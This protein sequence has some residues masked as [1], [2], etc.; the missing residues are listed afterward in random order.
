MY[1]TQSL[2]KKSNSKIA[3]NLMGVRQEELGIDY[4]DRRNAMVEAVTLEDVNRI[5]AK[6]LE[7]E[8][9]SFIVVGEPQGLDEVA[10]LPEAV[11]DDI[12]LDDAGDEE[13]HDSEE[14]KAMPD[15]D[16]G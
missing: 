5:A 10:T 8:N 16:H 1:I 15:P 14:T 7:P 4:F 12:T 13:E 3:S 11:G 9:F 2:Q 6:Y